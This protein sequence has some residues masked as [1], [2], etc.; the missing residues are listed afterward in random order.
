M[1]YAYANPKKSGSV[2][3]CEAFVAGV[4]TGSQRAAVVTDGV[5][6]KD[7]VAAVFYGIQK[8]LMQCW[9]DALKHGV[10]YWYIDNGYF[11]S[12]WKGGSYYRITANRL[13]HDGQGKSDGQR[14]AALGLAIKFW[15]RGGTHVLIAQQSPWWY[16]WQGGSIREWTEHAED[17]V[18]DWPAVIRGKPT[19][20]ELPPIDWAKIKCVLT[21]SSNVAI[22]GLLQGVP[23]LVTS[24][25]AAARTLAGCVETRTLNFP[26]NRREVFNVLADNQFTLSEIKSGFAWRMLTR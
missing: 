8:E 21:H 16:E 10:P 12:K 13:Q 3:M 2:E 6:R 9:R 22:D 17:I 5:L 14:F 15:R 18:R 7:G 20:K 4:R 24:E 25:Y 19:T 26:D 23:C 1:I 11:N